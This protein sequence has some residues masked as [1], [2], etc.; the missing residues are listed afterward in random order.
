MRVKFDEASHT[1]AIDGEIV[2]I[3]VT[4]LLRKHGL[5]PD[6]TG[7]STSVL[8]RASAHG[9]AVHADI[10]NA[11]N[12]QESTTKEAENFI[13]WA[14]WNADEMH[15]EQVVGYA[16]DGL[17]IAGTIDVFGELRRTNYRLGMGQLGGTFNVP[18]RMFFLGDHKTTSKV[19]LDYVTWQTSI[20]DYMLRQLDGQELNGTKVEWKGADKLYCFHYAKDGEM[21]EYE[22]HKVDDSEIERLF[23]CERKGEIYKS[24]FLT[25]PKEQELVERAQDAIE[26]L[27]RIEAERQD[28]E[29]YLKE[30]QAQLIE[31]F[32][33]HGVKKFENDV[34]RMTYTAP[35]TTRKIDTKAL[36]AEQPE[37]AEK[38]TKESEVKA[39]VRITLKGER[40]E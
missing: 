11:I 14:S 27:A 4:E 23:E 19:D 9:T 7:A 12:G 1:Y 10:A 30:L 40:D 38:Y 25:S 31:V 2:P 29:E 36:K 28:A 18:K 32:E 20:Y 17:M 24:S 16:K 39:S 21:R 15:A 5:A 6:Y 26:E 8:E 3:S 33:K 22:L 37:I 35:H 34:I 13:E